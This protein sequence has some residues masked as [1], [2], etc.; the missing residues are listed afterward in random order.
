MLNP[1]KLQFKL[2]SVTFM[3]LVLTDKG[4]EVDPVKVTAITNMPTPTN[5]KA[6][7]CHHG[8]FQYLSKFCHNLSSVENP[9]QLLT[10]EDTAFIW[11]EVQELTFTQSKDMIAKTLVLK[12]YD[13]KVPVILQVD[14]SEAGL[15]STLLQQSDNKWQLIVFTSCSL[16]FTAMNYAQ[17][18]KALA[19]CMAFD[20]ETNGCMVNMTS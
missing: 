16:S 14:S 6:L 15:G 17:I 18:E 20:S 5:K 13:K 4:V 19:I 9:L 1:T 3:G 10:C 8:M 7:Q 2:K 12:Y 11:T